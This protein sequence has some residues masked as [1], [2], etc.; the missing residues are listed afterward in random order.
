[1]ARAGVWIGGICDCDLWD[2]VWV[3]VWVWEREKEGE[4]RGGTATLT[5]LSGCHYG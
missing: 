3:W 2:W 4:P 1:M 5:K